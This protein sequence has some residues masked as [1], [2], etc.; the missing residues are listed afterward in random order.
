M[1]SRLVTSPSDVLMFSFSTRA[2]ARQPITIIPVPGSLGASPQPCTDLSSTPHSAFSQTYPMLRGQPTR[3]T[4]PQSFSVTTLP[5]ALSC[6]LRTM[7]T[8]P[9]LKAAEDFLSFVNASPTRMFSLVN[10]I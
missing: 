7:S 4:L 1:R 5:L 2:A 3:A 6:A 9:S 10:D 8:K